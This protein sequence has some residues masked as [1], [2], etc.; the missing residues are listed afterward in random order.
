[1]SMDVDSA[2]CL[3]SDASNTP[4]GSTV[5]VQMTVK[6]CKLDVIFKKKIDTSFFVV[7]Q[8]LLKQFLFFK[9]EYLGQICTKNLSNISKSKLARW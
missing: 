5:H 4:K 8:Q 1:M 6:N 3:R 7:F 9:L 2:G